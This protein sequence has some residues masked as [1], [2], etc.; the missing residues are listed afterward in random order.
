[1]RYVIAGGHGQIARHLTRQLV[2]DGHGVVGLI[3][4]PDHADDLKADGAEPTVLS[5]EE[6][7]VDEL[8]GVLKC[9]DGVIF[10][11]G[12]G[13]T[14]GRARKWTV[15]LL[16]AVLLADAAEAAGVRRYVMVSS[17]GANRP[18][19]VP[20]GTFQ[21]YLYAKGGADA[22]VRSREG[23]DWTIVRPGPLTDDAA[24]GTFTVNPDAE[25]T[26]ITRQDVASVVAWSLAH[27]ETI[28]KTFV[29]VNGDTPLDQLT[30]TSGA[31]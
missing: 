26:P 25:R 27:D 2:A 14:S 4:N 16:G 21:V 13:P 3:R 18:E 30:F 8:A 28:C 7:S 19:S 1:M 15:D 12:G 6:A 20:D 10:A 29:V 24:T 5:L 11:A 22:D 31:E 17:V 23:L 9:A